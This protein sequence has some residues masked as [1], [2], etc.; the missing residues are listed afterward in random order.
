MTD[1]LKAIIAKKE[2]DRTPEETEE[3]K[4]AVTAF[5]TEIVDVCQR[6][7]LEYKAALSYTSDGV[8]PT[9][10]VQVVAPAAAKE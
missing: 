5:K 6:H 7:G 4:A 9:L 10:V 3:L 1:S 2:A 8:L